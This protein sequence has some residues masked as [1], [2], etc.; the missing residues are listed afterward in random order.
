MELIFELLLQFLG[1][2]LLQLLFELLSELGLRSLADT[3]GK[4]RHPILSTIGF[5]LWGAIAGAISLWILPFSPIRNP[6][7]RV[8][9]LI[10]TPV[11]I[12]GVMMLIGMTRTRKGQLLVKLNRFGYAFAFAFAMALVRFLCVE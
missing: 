6:D 2:I 5:L 1:E 7:L 11:A 3:V 4:P 9:N 8:L 12:G 10:V